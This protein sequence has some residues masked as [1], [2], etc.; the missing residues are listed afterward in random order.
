[1]ILMCTSRDLWS[2]RRVWYPP[3]DPKGAYYRT[4]Y[5]GKTEKDG[6]VTVHMKLI[7]EEEWRKTHASKSHESPENTE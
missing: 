6:V 1:M 2:G 7:P 3:G 4:E 5:A